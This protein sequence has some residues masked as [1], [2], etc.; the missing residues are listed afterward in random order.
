VRPPK[1]REDLYEIIMAKKK[2]KLGKLK[3][4]G[5]LIVDAVRT[6]QSNLLKS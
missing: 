1:T 5:K 2:G 3:L 6:G 4:T